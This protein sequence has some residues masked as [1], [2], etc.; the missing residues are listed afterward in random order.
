MPIAAAAPR[1]RNATVTMTA[2]VKVLAHDDGL[3]T[4]REAE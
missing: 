1:V 2:I 3:Q 4:L